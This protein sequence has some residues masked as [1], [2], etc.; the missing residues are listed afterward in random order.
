MIRIDSHRSRSL[1]AVASAGEAFAETAAAAPRLKELVT[2][3]SEIVRIGDLVENAG[4]AADVAGVPR[5]RSRPDRRR[6]G[7]AHRRGAAPARHRPASTP[8]ASPKWW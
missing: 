8:A 6:A 3:T 1:M 2:V 4:A 7:R 5:A